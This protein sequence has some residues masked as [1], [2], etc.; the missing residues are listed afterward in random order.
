MLLSLYSNKF[1]CNVCVLHKLH[2]LYKWQ[3]CLKVTCARMLPASPV[4]WW[5]AASIRVR[6]ECC[7]SVG[8]TQN[9]PKARPASS[10]LEQ[11]TP[12]GLRPLACARQLVR[13]F[14]LGVRIMNI[15]DDR[16]F[17]PHYPG[18]SEALVRYPVAAFVASLAT[19]HH[20]PPLTLFQSPIHRLTTIVV[21]PLAPEL[22]VNDKHNLHQK[23][24]KPLVCPVL[25]EFFSQFCRA[26]DSRP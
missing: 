5:A 2:T 8:P 26:C 16:F 10:G 13:V 19:C 22:A 20:Y 15:E 14:I 9:T 11:T 24:T 12:T 23:G 17:A 1:A 6:V 25:R 3:A 4:T 18:S 7:A 21:P